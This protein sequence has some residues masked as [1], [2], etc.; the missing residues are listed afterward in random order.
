MENEEV[1]RRR[2]VL[3]RLYIACLLCTCFLIVEVAGGLLSHSLAVLSDAAHLLAD[4][5]SFAVASKFPCTFC[6]DIT[7]VLI[8]F[9]NLCS[10]CKLLSEFTS[11]AST[12]I[13]TEE[14]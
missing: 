14:D 6:C 3:R 8:V 1:I 10:W 4:L 11:Y 2:A 12:H 7:H 9:L 13:R 5:A